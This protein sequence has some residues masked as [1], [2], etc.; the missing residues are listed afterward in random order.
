MT[1]EE[2]DRYYLDEA[3]RVSTLSHDPSTQTGCVIVSEGMLLT[4]GW[5]HIPRGKA[6]WLADRAT[7]LKVVTHAEIHALASN[8]GWDLRG[9]TA[10]IHPWLPC[11]NCFSALVGAGIERV[12]APKMDEESDRYRRWKDDFDL[13]RE[14]A[15]HAGIGLV[16]MEVT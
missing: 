12:V 13:V 4:Y 5:N 9:A 7:K 3:R 14:Y 11:G 2:K 1:Q 16:E 10:Y 6:E 15:A 8:A